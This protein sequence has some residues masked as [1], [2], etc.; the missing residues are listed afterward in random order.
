MFY[1]GMLY[2]SRMWYRLHT[3]RKRVAK[4]EKGE[5]FVLSLDQT[6]LSPDNQAYQFS[7]QHTVILLSKVTKKNTII[8]LKMEIKQFIFINTEFSQG[9]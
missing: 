5:I 2:T 1:T 4:P 9:N 3:E 6:V 7:L 8:D